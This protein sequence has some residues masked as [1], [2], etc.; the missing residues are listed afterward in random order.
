[1]KTRDWRAAVIALGG[2]LAVTGLAMATLY[3]PEEKTMG[4]AQRIFYLHVPSAWIGFL[5]FGVVFV[6]SIAYLA[7]RR[8]AFD[9]A[10]AASTE[11]GVVFTTLAIASGAVW[12]RYAWGTWW[13]WDPRL[14]TTF[15]LWF[16]YVVSLMVRAYGGTGNQPSRFAAIPGLLGVPDLSPIPPPRGG[17]SRPAVL[18]VFWAA[19]CSRRGAGG[20]GADALVA[21]REQSFQPAGTN[22][23]AAPLG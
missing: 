19:L 10:A 22:A 5:A 20:G 23:P 21:S 2:I 16:I 8:R 4:D 17:G 18:P 6:S 12:G 13:S 3:A 14:T 7:T 9:L 1:M 11:V 15:M